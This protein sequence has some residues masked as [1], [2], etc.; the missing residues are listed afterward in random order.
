MHLTLAPAA[1]LSFAGA[2]AG[3]QQR[4]QHNSIVHMFA[5]EPVASYAAAA[6]ALLLLYANSSVAAAF[7]TPVCM[8]SVV[9]APNMQKRSAAAMLS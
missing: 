1:L 3:E 2:A 9:A 6:P 7:T 8:P 5:V 4:V